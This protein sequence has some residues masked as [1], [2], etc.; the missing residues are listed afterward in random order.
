MPEVE[1]SEWGPLRFDE[2]WPKRVRDRTLLLLAIEAESGVDQCEPCINGP[3]A[4]ALASED[5]GG[6]S[7]GGLAWEAEF[8]NGL[9]GS[10]SK[11]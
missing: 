9:S 5:G 10:K 1:L 6:T 8:R 2:G 11:K 7:S 4:Y 3:L